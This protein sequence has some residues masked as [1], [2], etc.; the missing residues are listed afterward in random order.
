MTDKAIP[1]EA[2]MT[3]EIDPKKLTLDELEELEAFVGQST[4]AIFAGTGFSAKAM[5]ALVFIFRRRVDPAFTIEDAGRANL[6][7][8]TIVGG[9]ADPTDAVA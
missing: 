5:K 4:E 9:D 1:A 8:I 6:S 2:A 3:I 7:D